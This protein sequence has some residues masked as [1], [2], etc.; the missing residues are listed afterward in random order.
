MREGIFGDPM[1]GGNAGKAGWELIG[2]PGV[3]L[4]PR[5]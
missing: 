5:K 4:H 3:K 1:Y 2:F